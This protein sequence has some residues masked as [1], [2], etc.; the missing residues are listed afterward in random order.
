MSA[1]KTT[2]KS[3]KKAAKKTSRKV[4]KKVTKKVAK[5]AVKKKAAK[6]ARS[7]PAPSYQDLEREAYF[8]FLSRC[9]QGLPGSPEGDWEVARQRLGG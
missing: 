1:K 3:A 2:K 6:L 9:E 7:V 5:K 8:V 4:A